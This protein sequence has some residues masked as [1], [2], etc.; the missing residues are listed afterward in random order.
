MKCKALIEELEETRDRV[1]FLEADMSKLRDAK[2]ER[3]KGLLQTVAALRAQLKLDKDYT[4]EPST[5]DVTFDPGVKKD[6]QAAD[7]AVVDPDVYKALL[8]ENSRLMKVMDGGGGGGRT[9]SSKF[10]DDRPP[11]AGPDPFLDIERM[12]P[13]EV[14]SFLSNYLNA[15][16]LEGIA[17]LLDAQYVGDIKRLETTTAHLESRV[18][19]EA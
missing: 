6:A 12:Q 5:H 17:P 14:V 15:E 10:D 18:S 9:Q 13:H 1:G 11:A 16:Q 2:D 3:I 19:A 7:L 4:V 8:L